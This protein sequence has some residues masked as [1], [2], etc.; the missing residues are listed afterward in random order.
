LHVEL[1]IAEGQRQV[2]AFVTDYETDDFLRGRWGSPPAEMLSM[3]ADYREKVRAAR[4]KAIAAGII[5]D[6]PTGPVFPS[7]VQMVQILDDPGAKEAY[8]LAYRRL[9]SDVHVGTWAFEKG[10]FVERTGGLVSYSEPQDEAEL[11]ATRTLVAT[12]FASTLCIVSAVLDLGIHD[13]A[14]EIKRT[15]VPSEPPIAERM[16]AKE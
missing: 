12:S 11:H 6:K 10:A 3:R 1:W 9:T 16:N 7:T 4:A 15:Y 2:A 5:P 13:Q 14:D 8:T